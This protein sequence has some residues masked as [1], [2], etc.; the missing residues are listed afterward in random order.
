MNRKAERKATEEVISTLQV[1][2]KDAEVEVNHLSGGNQQKI[3]IGK[4]L[5]DEA[6]VYLF[7]EPTKGVDIGAKR[8]I[9]KLIQQLAKEGKAILY[10]SSEIQELLT[11]CHRVLV[12]YDGKFVKEFTQEK[13]TQE[14]ILLYAS[15]GKEVNHEGQIDRISI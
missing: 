4:W 5:S 9:L 2:T 8:E 13:A 15:G 10:F 11:V 7:D 12:M 14:K 6:K 3:V 1:K